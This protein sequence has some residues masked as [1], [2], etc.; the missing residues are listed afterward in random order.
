M[1]GSAETKGGCKFSKL[2]LVIKFDLKPFLKVG[3]DLTWLQIIVHGK[4]FE[5][6]KDHIKTLISKDQNFHSFYTRV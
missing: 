1:T 5:E 4:I 3:V 6:Q 2:N